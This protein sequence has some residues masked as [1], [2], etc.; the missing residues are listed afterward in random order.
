MKTIKNAKEASCLHCF[1]SSG[2][3]IKNGRVVCGRCG[4]S[5][6]IDST[7]EI[8]QPVFIDDPAATY[9]AS[10][11]TPRLPDRRIMNRTWPKYK[12]RRVGMFV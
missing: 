1:F 12:E 5:N 9:Q 11:Y 8:F 3:E 6:L 7:G 2:A 4:S 10:Q